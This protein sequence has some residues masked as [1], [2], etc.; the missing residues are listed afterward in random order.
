ME[1]AHVGA[2]IADFITDGVTYAIVTVRLAAASVAMLSLSEAV[3][4]AYNYVEGCAKSV[5]NLADTAASLGVDTDVTSAH[6]DAATLMRGVLADA[7]DLAAE[8]EEMA[9]DFQSAKE[10]H[11][12]DYGPVHEAMTN[13]PGDEADRTYYGNR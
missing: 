13:K 4:G 8:A 10:D 11:E 1:H 3:R 7:E 6:Y 12:A 2:R 9:R 5:D